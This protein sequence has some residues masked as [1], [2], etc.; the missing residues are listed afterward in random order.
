M[1]RANHNPPMMY[2]PTLRRFP[3]DRLLQTDGC[4]SYAQAIY[5]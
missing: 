3:N 1:R 2:Q 5:L 4:N